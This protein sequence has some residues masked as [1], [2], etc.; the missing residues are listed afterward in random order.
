MKHIIMQNTDT[1]ASKFESLH[2]HSK[3]CC[4]WFFLMF[5]KEGSTKALFDQIPVKQ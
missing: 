2:Y 1:Q 3:V 5:L 4:H